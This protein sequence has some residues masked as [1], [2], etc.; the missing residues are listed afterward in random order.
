[1]SRVQYWT[2][3][4]FEL[5]EDGRLGSDHVVVASRNAIT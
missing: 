5:G 1:M 4:V 3:N 2:R